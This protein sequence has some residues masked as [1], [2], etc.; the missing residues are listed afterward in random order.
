MLNLP[1]T[2]AGCEIP[3]LPV[4]DECDVHPAPCLF[5]GR[6]LEHVNAG[7]IG[8]IV[9]ALVDGESRTYLRCNEGPCATASAPWVWWCGCAP[10]Y[11]ENVGDHCHDCRR[12]RYEAE[13]YDRVECLVCGETR[14][15]DDRLGIGNGRCL[16]CTGG[17]AYLP[18]LHEVPHPT[19]LAVLPGGCYGE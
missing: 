17:P 16:S 2:L 15:L 1:Y 18:V 19:S 5:C 12:P 11:V 7:G 4:R 8:G 6:M 13:P 9:G 3:D 10:D 14:W